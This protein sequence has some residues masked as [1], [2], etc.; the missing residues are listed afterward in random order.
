[1]THLLLL[2]GLAMDTRDRLV[3]RLAHFIAKHEGAASG[4]LIYV[5]Q[6]GA[7]RGPGGYAQ[8][9]TEEQAHEALRRDLARKLGRGL[10]PRQ[11]LQRWCH[12]GPCAYAWRLQL[13]T[14]IEPD[15]RFAE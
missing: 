12:P 1:M 11:V 8:W 6:R 9:Q 15:R 3:D 2:L 13:E 10:S 4:N 5:G 14:G 7:V